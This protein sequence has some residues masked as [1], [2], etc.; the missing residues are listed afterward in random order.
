MKDSF[1]NEEKVVNPPRIP[2]A[3]NKRTSFEK[4]H[5]SAYPTRIPIRRQPMIF[6]TKVP[7]GNP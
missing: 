2:V 5:R 6:T 7:Q 3:I 1:E 4:S